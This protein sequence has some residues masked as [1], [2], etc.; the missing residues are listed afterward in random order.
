[1]RLARTAIAA[2][3]LLCVAETAQARGRL[4]ERQQTPVAQERRSVVIDGAHDLVAVA[5]RFLGG[6]KFTRQPGPWCAD[7]VSAWLVASGHRPLANR[8]AGSALAYGPRIAVPR[9]GDLV[10]LGY[11]RHVGIVVADLGGSVEMVSGNWSHR[12]KRAIVSK[13]GATFVRVNT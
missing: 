11:G 3:A 1:M 13:R 4:S 12:V 8:M 5:E 6:G 7:A 10:V 9:R 2:L